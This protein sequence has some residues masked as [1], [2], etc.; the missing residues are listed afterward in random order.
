MAAQAD[1]L[2]VR[3]QAHRSIDHRSFLPSKRH[4]GERPKDVGSRLRIGRR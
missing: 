3:A 2:D 1:H 4:I